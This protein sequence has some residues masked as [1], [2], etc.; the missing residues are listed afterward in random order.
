LKRAQA[1]QTQFATSPLAGRLQVFS[2]YSAE[3]E[4]SAI[5]IQIR[6]WLLEGK[7]SIAVVTE[8]RLQ[9]RRL[10]ALLERANIQLQDDV[11]WALSTTRAAATLE[12]LFICVED[13]FPKDALLDLLKSPL[14]L[15]DEEREQRMHLV[16]RLEHDIIQQE[17][18]ACNLEQYKNAISQRVSDLQD[19]WTVSPAALLNLLNRVETATHNL[20]QMMRGRHALAEF[21]EALQQTIEQL[22]LKSSLSEDAA[23][24]QILRILEQMQEATLQQPLTDYWSGLRAWLGRNLENHYFQPQSTGSPVHLLSL[25]Q[26]E[27]QYF[28]AVIVA[29]MEQDFFPGNMPSVPF[30]NS[31]VRSQL[32][33]PEIVRFR[34]ARL[35]HFNRLLCSAPAL[36]LSHRHEQNAQ[37]II[38]SPWLSAITQFHQL[39]YTDNLQATTLHDVVASN[40]AGVF[41]CDT[42]Q[43]P[44]KQQQPRPVLQTDKIPTTYSASSYQQLI[45]CPYQFYAAQYLKL[46][47]PEEIRDLLTKREYGERIHQCLQAFHSDVPY[48]PGPFTEPLTKANRQQAIEVLQHI[49]DQVFRKDLAASYLHRGWYYPWIKLIP[50]Y[51][52]W[53]IKQS[54]ATTV[55]LTEQ[56]L[57]R[58]LGPAVRIKGRIDRIDVS[59]ANATHQTIIDY[60]TGGI[61]TEDE[62]FSGE[63]L[64]LPFYAALAGND[65]REVFYLLFESNTGVKRKVTIADDSLPSLKSDIEQR[66]LQLVDAMQSGRG[67]P[68]WEN[69]KVCQ[70][71]NMITLCRCG[72]WQ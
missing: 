34:A 21:V 6:Q 62:V 31:A 55:H 49:A 39:A 18:I 19:I 2:A 5:D 68:A 38:P 52:D 32:G 42:R 69:D 48:L 70:Y 57:E 29:S 47:P 46:S 12:S 10:R 16:Y 20:R 60:K 13:D 24:Y 50:D 37:V 51:I 61:P 1:Q 27:F 35:R 3:Q 30:F 53:Q 17:K 63:K 41:R 26:S 58:E 67:L 8:N 66:L 14:L 44:E 9:A 65:T 25:A 7:Q 40:R 33:L 59:S 23:G 72:T 15:A 64:Q 22:G 28:D 36:L 56:K 11:G 45:D 71:C 54:Q 4:T 43:L